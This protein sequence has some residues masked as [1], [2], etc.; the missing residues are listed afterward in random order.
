[1]TAEEACMDA[2]DVARWT[3]AIASQPAAPTVKE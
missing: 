3:F 2:V 1:M